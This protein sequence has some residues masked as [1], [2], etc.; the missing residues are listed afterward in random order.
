MTPRQTNHPTGALLFIREPQ[1]VH[2]ISHSPPLEFHYRWYSLFHSG[3]PHKSLF[4]E[5]QFQFPGLT[6]P[7]GNPPP[8]KKIKNFSGAFHVSATETRAARGARRFWR[9][10]SKPRLAAAWLASQAPEK[11]AGGRGRLLVARWVVAPKEKPPRKTPKTGTTPTEIP[12]L[13]VALSLSKTRLH[14]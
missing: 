1:T 7:S 12:F 9:E 5:P 4:R 11:V 2:S 13:C 8:Q 14:N 6:S 10:V 3:N